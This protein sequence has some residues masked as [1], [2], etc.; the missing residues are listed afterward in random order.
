MAAGLQVWDADGNLVLD[1]T[2]MRIARIT[3]TTAPTPT[4]SE[5]VWRCRIPLNM[6]NPQAG[7]TYK[8]FYG[9]Y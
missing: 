1:T 9:L 8:E 6:T 7:L 4:G 5:Q 3:G 2:S